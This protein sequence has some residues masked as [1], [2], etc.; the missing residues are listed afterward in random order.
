MLT[1]WKVSK[2]SAEVIE[3]GWVMLDAKKCEEV[4]Q[5]Y[6]IPRRYLTRKIIDAP[7]ERPSEARQHSYNPA[8]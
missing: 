8:V 4:V 5:A 7:R 2:D 1:H 6:S 3:L